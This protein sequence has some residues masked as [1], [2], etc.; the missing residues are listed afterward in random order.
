MITIAFDDEP[1]D[2]SVGPVA[3]TSKDTL[4]TKTTTM[5]KKNKNKSAALSKP[6]RML[7]A[8]NYFFHHHRQLILAQ[9][10]HR[11]HGERPKNGHGKINFADLAREVSARWKKASDQ[12]KAYFIQL[13]AQ[14]KQRYTREI[15]EWKIRDDIR[16]EQHS[17]E[18]IHRFDETKMMEKV[19]L[20]RLATA[21][22]DDCEVFV[23]L[24]R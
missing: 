20:H 15:K 19:E 17:S 18:V 13:S 10:P 14:D 11:E 4:A 3:V 21:L 6:K 5:N 9:I 16:K 2:W 8:Y 1:L 12:E 23:R 22:G 24:F 7:N